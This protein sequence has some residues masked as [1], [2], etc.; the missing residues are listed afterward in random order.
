MKRRQKTK[1]EKRWGGW[2][3]RQGADPNVIESPRLPVSAPDISA[4]ITSAPAM[5]GLLAWNMASSA[6]KNHGRNVGGRFLGVASDLPQ[7]PIVIPTYAETPPGGYQT[8]H[9]PTKKSPKFQLKTPHKISGPTFGQAHPLTHPLENPRKVCLAAASTASIA[10]EM[11]GQMEV[12]GLT[13]G[14]C[15][16]THAQSSVDSSAMQGG[17][18]ADRIWHVFIGGTVDRLWGYLLLSAST[19]A[20]WISPFSAV[21]KK[22][23]YTFGRRQRRHV[24]LVWSSIRVSP[25]PSIQQ[26][27][28]GDAGQK[29]GGG[30]L[31]SRLRASTTRHLAFWRQCRDL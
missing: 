17:N 19:S 16:R 21:Q 1:E 24:G 9:P 20:S 2:G 7:V 31:K 25:L 8:I 15:Q 12:V 11:D 5:A 22:N 28:G 29:G 18:K 6:C 14:H 3:N 23:A 30:L 27:P 4:R 13:H 10:S 26:T